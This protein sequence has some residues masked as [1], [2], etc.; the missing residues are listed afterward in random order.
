MNTTTSFKSCEK[1]V[2]NENMI[3][4]IKIMKYGKC[5]IPGG[6]NILTEKGLKYSIKNWS[7]CHKLTLVRRHR[8]RLQQEEWEAETFFHWWSH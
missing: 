3:M 6:C 8:H 2:Q 4:T 1:K 7:A 5:E